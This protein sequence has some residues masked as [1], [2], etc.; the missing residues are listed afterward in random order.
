MRLR[1]ILIGTLS[2]VMV[3]LLASGI[4]LAAERAYHH[5]VVLGDPHLPGGTLHQ[6][7]Q[8]RTT[9]N[10]WNDVDLVVAV[11]DI[12]EEVGDDDEYAKA[13]AYF[14]LFTKPLALIGGNH[15]YIYED[16]LSITGRKIKARESTRVYKL[17]HFKKTFG[18][19]EIYY[20]KSMGPY[21]LVFLTPDDLQASALTTISAT[22]YKW[23]AAILAANK[24]KPTIVFFHGPL[25]GTLDKYNKNADTYDYVAQP[26]E[27]IRIILTDNPQVILWVSGH[28]HTSPKEPSFASTVN[29]YEGR[30]MNIHTTD[31]KRKNIY[32][33]SLFLY[34]EGIV[35]KT[36]DHGKGDWMPGLERKVQRSRLSTQ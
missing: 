5:I 29:L 31:M 20:T 28:T 33:N 7:E 17:D 12:T 34:D 35:V 32:T 8:V 2:L 1:R 18:L 30:V 19:H 26:S 36:F 23:F 22:Q 11:G 16:S 3:L 27:E 14:D 13:K 21:L 24:N 25:S 15:D 10:G 6:K 4:S 9:V